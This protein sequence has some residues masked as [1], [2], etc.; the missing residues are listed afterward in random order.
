MNDQFRRLSGL[1]DVRT[2][3][4]LGGNVSELLK[5]LVEMLNASER[6]LNAHA[7]V[8]SGTEG[9]A[10]HGATVTYGSRP[11]ASIALIANQTKGM[12]TM[13][14]IRIDIAPL[15][16]GKDAELELS[17]E[18]SRTVRDITYGQKADREMQKVIRGGKV[19]MT[20]LSPQTLL[21]PTEAFWKKAADL[22]PK[23]MR[24]GEGLS[25]ESFDIL[26]ILDRGPTAADYQTEWVDLE[27]A[28]LIKQ[29]I[30][31]AAA[32]RRVYVITPAGRAALEDAP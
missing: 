17:L 28:G 12:I 13:D 14:R 18:V 24:G 26:R 6:A 20:N 25:I 30:P 4:V 19:E 9:W 10:S 29:A 31:G 2:E 27:T 23:P 15:S 22:R 32:G 5:N 8:L 3:A 16:E 21:G 7:T 1:S 11:R